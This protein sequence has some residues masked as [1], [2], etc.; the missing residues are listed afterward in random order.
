ML[1]LPGH[2]V[3]SEGARMRIRI[4]SEA[5]LILGFVVG[6]LISPAT[7]YASVVEIKLTI[8]RETVHITGNPT[9]GMTING[10]IPGPTLRFRQGDLARIH[11]Q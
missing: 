4:F 1:L 7:M 11:V 5:I 6:I 9:T 8:A 3:F 10:G 2:G